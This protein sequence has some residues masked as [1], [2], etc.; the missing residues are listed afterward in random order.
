MYHTVL[1][2]LKAFEPLLK[3][4]VWILFSVSGLLSAV[5]WFVSSRAPKIK[6]LNSLAAGFAG[7][8]ILFSLI[9]SDQRYYPIFGPIFGFI[10]FV[11]CLTSV[12][13]E[14]FYEKFALRHYDPL[15][16][17][18]RVIWLLQINKNHIYRAINEDLNYLLDSK[19]ALI[20]HFSGAYGTQRGVPF[21]KDMQD[22]LKNGTDWELS[23]SV[24]TPNHQMDLWGS[25]GVVL[26]P[27]SSEN[28]LSV[29]HGD[30]GSSNIDGLEQSLG[31]SLMTKS[32]EDSI[33]R[34]A[35]GTYNEWRV[36]GAKTD[37]IFVK[38]PN[39]IEVRCIKPV[40]AAGTT[41]E[42]ND[43]CY[44]SLDEVK[45]YFPNEKIWTMGKNGPELLFKP[46]VPKL[47]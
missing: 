13:S 27:E 6:Q 18:R 33:N 39:N 30:S 40:E 20:V 21:P 12:F 4:L 23:C 3:D 24:L 45:K 46:P 22:V 28:V 44:P 11:L 42:T 8:A 47:S 31:L 17:I 37:G 10:I 5:F 35:P 36:K 15:G 43:F 14:S 25:L 34:V 1:T 9:S 19:K 32:F 2:I 26:R 29:S 38:D 41:I 16:L 7:S